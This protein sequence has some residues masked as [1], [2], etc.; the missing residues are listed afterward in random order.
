[1]IGNLISAIKEVLQSGETITEE[2]IK[3][4]ENIEVD[5]PTDDVEN[6]V[7]DVETTEDIE[8]TEND[9]VYG[10]QEIKKEIEVLK[11]ENAEIKEKY[12]NLVD[13]SDKKEEPEVIEEDDKVEKIDDYMEEKD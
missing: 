12:K 3:D 5:K 4:I 13:F 8:I 6:T 10:Y 11:Q 2:D 7:E 9:E 1:M